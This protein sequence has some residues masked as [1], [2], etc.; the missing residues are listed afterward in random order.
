MHRP[1]TTAGGRLGV[2]G[3]VGVAG[4]SDG[5]RRPLESIAAFL[6]ELAATS[7]EGYVLTGTM[8]GMREVPEF[9]PGGELTSSL[10]IGTPPPAPGFS[11]STGTPPLAAPTP[12]TRPP[13]PTARAASMDASYGHGEAVVPVPT[14]AV[15]PL[16]ALSRTL[17]AQQ[18]PPL[19]NFTRDHTD[20]DG[21]S[22]EEWSERLEM[23]AA[24]CHWDDQTKLVNT[25]TRLRGSASRFHR[26]CSPQQRSN[27]MALTTA[28]KQRFTPVCIQAVQSSRFH[29]RKQ[30]HKES[31]DNYAQ[32]LRRFYYHAY[33]SSA[34]TEEA[35]RM[36]QSVL[37][38][39]FVA[40]L[41]GGLKSK[42]VG[43]E[44]TFEQLLA[45]ARFEEARIRDIDYW[46][47]QH[48]HKTFTPPC[49]KELDQTGSGGQANPKSHKSTLT[50]YHC[51]GTGHFARQCPKKG[52]GVPR[53]AQG[54]KQSNT[55]PKPG[56]SM[57]LADRGENN[58]PRGELQ[59]E[60][61]A[62]PDAVDEAVLKVMAKMFRIL[63]D[64]PTTDATLGPTPTSEILLDGM[65]TAALVDTGSP[66]S[67]V[68]LTFFLEAAAANRE[69]SQPPAAWGKAVRQ[70]LRPATMSLRCYGGTQLAIVGQ[71]VCRLAIKGRAVDTLLKV[72]KNA[73]VDLLL[74]TDTLRQLGF[75]LS[76]AGQGDLLAKQLEFDRDGENKPQPNQRQAEDGGG[77]TIGSLPSV[78]SRSCTNGTTV[79]LI[80]ATRV[81]A[82]HVNII[83]AGL[84]GLGVRGSDCLFEPA[85]RVLH[86]KG[87]STADAVVEVGDGDGVNLVIANLSTEPVLLQEG[88]VLGE[89]QPA[90]LIEH[91]DDN[92]PNIPKVAAI[93]REKGCSGREE[94]LWTALDLDAA[95]L[96]VT[97][98]ELLHSLVMEFSDVFALNSSELGRTS[99]TTHKIDTGDSPPLRQPPRHVP[100][101]LR[102]KV[103]SLVEDMLE[104]GVITPSSSPWASPIFL[105]AKKDGSTRFCVDYR[106][107]NTVTKLD[108][109]PL[110]RIDDSLD[111]L[112]GTRY[113]SSL[114]L[115]S[116]YWQVGMGEESQEKTAFL[117]H[118]GLYEFAVMPFG[119]CNAP[120][121]FQRL[122]EEVLR[123]L[124]REKC[125]IYLDDVLVMGRTFDE[126]LSNLREI[127][128]RLSRAGLRLKPSKCKLVRREVEFLG[129]NVS[130]GG[131]SAD[132]RKV[133][134]VTEYPRPNDLRALRAFLGLLS[135]YRR[136]IPQFSAIA[137]PLYSLTRK[138]T[139]FLWSADCKT[140]FHQLK[141]Q[142]TLAPVLAYPQF[143]K[144]FL[145]ETDASGVGLGA[146]LSQK[147]ED[148][149][150]RPIA[151]ASR[152]LQ[153]HEKNYGI[154]EMEG[155]GVVW[156]V[157]HFRHYIYGHH[158]TV[159]TDH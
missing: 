140:A 30:G 43:R 108:V 8:G 87:L 16:D 118:A 49:G 139:P 79:K 143:G 58:K 83:R 97:E 109:H 138:D 62:S 78:D 74:G 105:V 6:P 148:G 101:A 2:G 114:D 20:G 112:A 11:L 56:V 150:I 85:L 131:I 154:S 65:P 33:A 89:I 93:A 124:A 117:T 125:L 60:T 153:P 115:A 1:T 39:Q 152:T 22:F 128:M 26:S 84:E 53:E 17:L 107:L 50:C 144:D 47:D 100:F 111:L 158:C 103:D 96:R 136:F 149:T 32:D 45:A 27:Y 91:I 90:A 134:A 133:R 5:A 155:L 142:L 102:G 122:M 147:Q 12:G 31:V 37:T 63:P 145:L 73:P 71:A 54:S 36:G 77:G 75:T 21:E 55:H 98:C 130:G 129:Y 59:E 113:F 123:G 110:P 13:L 126:H 29:E 35:D 44:G 38:Y 51:G 41:V 99:I 156:A 146:V 88:E 4:A 95:D 116:G 119:L 46:G 10:S 137:Q 42:L 159:Y 76:Q 52:R 157:K 135:Y 64:E 69:K 67:F 40:G 18:L 82:G 24:T 25:A 141:G 121:T 86:A 68:S 3:G 9:V 23:V 28:L 15:A 72:Q 127:F 94:E 19:P 120:A 80:Q 7:K 92:Q 104:Q 61:N 34:I 66:V 151:F 106:R 14:L 57:L 132:P 48:R 70:R 81:P